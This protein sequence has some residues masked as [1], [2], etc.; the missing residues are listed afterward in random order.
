MEIK[1]MSVI[2]EKYEPFKINF[3]DIIDSSVQQQAAQQPDYYKGIENEISIADPRLTENFLQKT[4]DNAN[5]RIF[6]SGR[7]VA[8]NVHE[9]TGQYMFKIIDSETK[10]I[11]KEVPPE[12]T[13]DAIAKMWELA[14]IFYDKKW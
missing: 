5:H 4:I 9:G 7:E 10:E 12:K 6:G 14:G 13:L 3:S 1:Q 2:M 11:L 8:Y